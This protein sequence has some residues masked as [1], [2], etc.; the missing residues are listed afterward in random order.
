MPATSLCMPVGSRTP[1]AGGLPAA[2]RRNQPEHRT[3]LLPVRAAGSAL[4]AVSI[5]AP[6]STGRFRR[7]P[8]RARHPEGGTASGALALDGF[9]DRAVH[10]VGDLV[11]ELD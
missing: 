2:K 11:R 6:V 8:G 1:D 10:P 4:A 3:I 9:D 5:A 7:M